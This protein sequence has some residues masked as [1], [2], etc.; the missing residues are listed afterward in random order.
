MSLDGRTALE[1][2]V[3]QWITGAAARTDGHAFRRRAGAVLTGV[4]TVLDDDPRLTCAP[5][6]TASNRCAWWSIR[7]WRRRPRRSCSRRPARC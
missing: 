6:E 7:A 2:G 3:S 1:N 4:G 5:V